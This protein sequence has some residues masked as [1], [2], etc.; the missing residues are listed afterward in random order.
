MIQ[1]ILRFLAGLSGL[2][3][4][5]LGLMLLFAPAKQSTPFAVLATGNAGLSTMRGDLGA[6]FLGMA[7]FTLVGAIRGSAQWLAVP[8]IFLS[9]VVLGRMLN[10]MLDGRSK[11]GVQAA[12]L[13]V[14]LIALLLLTMAS[15]PRRSDR[16]G[17]G[18]WLVLPVL[19]LLTLGIAFRYQGQIGMRL[20]QELV[21]RAMQNQ[22]LAGLPDGLHAGLCGS[23]APLADPTRAGPCVFVIAG[24]HVYVV[25][26]GEGSP[27]KMSLM[28]LSPGLIDGILLTHFHSDHIGGL[29]EMMLQ[30]WGM[31]NHQDQVPVI[32]PQGVEAV[33]KGFNDAYAL[34]KSYRV[35]HHG[36]ATMPPSGSGGVAKPFKLVDGSEQGQVVV[37]QDG[38]TI[39]AFAVN[40]APV[41]PAA[42]YR[43]DYGGRSVV[44]SGDTAPS[45][46]LAKFAHGC[47][48]LFHEGLQTAMVTMM[49]DAAVRNGR[50]GAA[51]ILAD[52]PSYHT[53]PE[54]AA[55]IA[56]SAGVR[57]L[58]FYHTIPPLPFA[59]LNAAFLGDAPK[60][61]RGPITV[62]K[63]GMMLSLVPG[64]TTV[65]MRE[66]L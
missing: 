11:E 4:L 20:N 40:H 3:F 51:K 33:V 17:F 55:R 64:S 42:G 45:P 26:A 23:G 47:D 9:L 2:L 10:L 57:Y 24:K 38:L 28:G 49:Q 34:D 66:L 18:Y 36:E 6:L 65:T 27:R 56:Q 58:M 43:F 13:E 31:A 41:F 37:E 16:R 60:I 32:G 54:D 14:I 44:I 30:R 48:L 46:V 22:L 63:D 59:Y 8:A 25:D 12:V 35:V 7:L 19:P 52:I 61:F 39:T 15:L 50:A 53:T 1:R 21:E 62:G 29:G 5:A